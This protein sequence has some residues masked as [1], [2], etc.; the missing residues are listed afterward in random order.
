MVEP[1]VAYIDKND[2]TFSN[3]GHVVNDLCANSLCRVTVVDIGANITND[4][5]NTGH[6]CGFSI[7]KYAPAMAGM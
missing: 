1:N 6:Q 3:H 4:I 7:N 2:N 5:S